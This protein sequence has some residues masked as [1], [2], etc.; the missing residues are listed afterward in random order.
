MLEHP[1]RTRAGKTK[2]A[3]RICV[4]ANNSPILAART[5][6]SSYDRSRELT[7]LL[8]VWPHEIADDTP[9]ARA[10]IVRRLRRALRRERQRGVAGHWAYD[11]SRHMAL[12]R[13]Y[14][15]EL[16]RLTLPPVDTLQVG[17]TPCAF[18]E[19]RG[20]RPVAR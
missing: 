6:A 14:R 2:T 15:F 19:C 1:S 13:A 3:P 18:V 8:P 16:E 20:S 4:R 11:L 10:A 9:T 7:R 5:G 17:S 12:V